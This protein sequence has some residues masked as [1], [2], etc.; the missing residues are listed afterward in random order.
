MTLQDV[1]NSRCTT[2]NYETN[3]FIILKSLISVNLFVSSYGMGLEKYCYKIFVL[4]MFLNQNMIS[5]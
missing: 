4:Q 1:E 3:E 5:R 2:E